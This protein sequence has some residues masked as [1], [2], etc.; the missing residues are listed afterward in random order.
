MKEPTVADLMTHPVVTVS[1]ATPF[2]NL[3]MVLTHYRIGSVPVLDSHQRPIGVVSEADLMS[4]EDQR[5]RGEPKSWWS[6]PKRWTRFNKARGTTAADLMTTPVVTI[7]AD[8][9]VGAAAR[10]LTSR[11]LRR[12]YV[13]ES[14][15]Q[16]VGVL[17]RRDVL[18]VFLRQDDELRADI[19]REVLARC[20]WA[21]P[22]L[23][24]VLVQDGE[25][26]LRGK[27]ELHSEAR[28]AVTLTEAIPGV[29]AVYNELEF[30]IDDL[31]PA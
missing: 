13:V 12:V 24:G 31:A 25:V 20:L 3:V 30:T 23:T 15:G 18:H 2:K 14:S 28:R 29:V 16:L 7:R 27:V 1:A 5:G 6:G 22:A 8:E 11:K 26:T 19:E 17:S 10:L 9:P 21:D 4:K